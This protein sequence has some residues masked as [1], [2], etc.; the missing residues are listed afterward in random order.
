MGSEQDARITKSQRAKLGCSQL[1][2][3]LNLFSGGEKRVVFLAIA[4]RMG[5]G[6]YRDDARL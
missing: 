5:D 4:N 1:L 6:Y 2:A 3:L